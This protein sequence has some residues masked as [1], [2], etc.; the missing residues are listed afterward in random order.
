MDVRSFF[1]A[2]AGS[3]D[4]KYSEEGGRFLNHFFSDRL[5]TAVHGLALDG[6][7]VVDI[8]AGTGQLYNYLS[9]IGSESGYLA[10]DVSSGMLDHSRIP[11]EK[12]LVGRLDQ[13]EEE[14]ADSSVDCFFML[15]VT[16]YMSEL[17][18][19]KYFHIMSQKA[20]PGALAIVTISNRRSVEFFLQSVASRLLRGARHVGLGRFDDRVAAQTFKRNCMT[21]NEFRMLL[22]NESSMEEVSALNQ[23]F[24]PLNRLFPRFSIAAEDVIRRLT[25]SQSV[26]RRGLSSDLLIR[27]RLRS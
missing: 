12:R 1:D 16:T 25:R 3:Y 22:P 13:V 26:I 8:G 5:R 18:I 17:E 9:A 11:L 23:T 24:T 21:L 14:I 20:A 6:R 10:I 7:R 2:I 27:V 4:R 19:K 15:G